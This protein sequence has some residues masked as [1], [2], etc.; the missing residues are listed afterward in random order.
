MQ[1]LEC[2]ARAGPETRGDAQERSGHPDEHVGGQPA[3]AQD[4]AR[5][6]RE[7]LEELGSEHAREEGGQ[8]RAVVRAGQG[9]HALHPR[10]QRFRIRA[11]LQHEVGC[12]G[13]PGVQAA[14]RM[15]HQ[16]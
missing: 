6:N 10:G 5:E 15:A 9:D 11:S 12:D 7:D 14:A 3:R 8:R 2:M 1:P 16:V 4:V 13:Q